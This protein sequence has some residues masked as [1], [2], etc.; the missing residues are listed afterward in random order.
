MILSV[1]TGCAG[2]ILR[3]G[4]E[5]R[6]ARSRDC[7][8]ALRRTPGRQ[9]PALWVVPWRAPAALRRSADA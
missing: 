8:R 6:E 2:G 9:T 7:G 3:R 4:Q 1:G 5:K